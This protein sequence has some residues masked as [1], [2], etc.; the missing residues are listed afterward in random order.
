MPLPSSGSISLA[1][2]QAE[3]GDSGSIALS[4]LYTTSYTKP[5]FIGKA[6]A[7]SNTTSSGVINVPNDAEPSDRVYLY[8]VYDNSTAT[9]PSITG[10]TIDT[11]FNGSYPQ[12]FP[13]DPSTTL[14]MTSVLLSGEVGDTGYSITIPNNSTYGGYVAALVVLRDVGSYSIKSSD[15]FTNPYL[16]RSQRDYIMSSSVNDL[17]IA[18]GAHDGSAETFTSWTLDT[19][20][21]SSYTYLSVDGAVAGMAAAIGVLSS[22][23][24]H[25]SITL[26]SPSTAASATPWCYFIAQG[27]KTQAS[28]TIV[29][30]STQY[31][32]PATGS[33][34]L[35]D[36][37]GVNNVSIIPLQLINFANYSASGSSVNIDISSYVDYKD[38]WLIVSQG[39]ADGSSSISNNVIITGN[40]VI[41]SNIYNS[42]ANINLGYY[43][44]LNTDGD[45]HFA[46]IT[47]AKLQ[48]N[49][50]TTSVQWV[51]SSG[52]YTKGDFAAV[53]LLTSVPVLNTVYAN[54]DISGSTTASI[55]LPS[56]SNQAVAVLV[57]VPNVTNA[58]VAVSN[59]SLSFTT[60]NMVNFWHNTLQR[61]NTVYSTANI[62][63]T[64]YG[65]FAG[66]S[67]EF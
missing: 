10:M 41:S 25:N 15:E 13:T 65:L 56:S 23:N 59:A 12:V 42:D 9:R 5:T 22:N 40:T 32:I 66:V 44:S 45:G 49:T 19:D 7:S 11:S 67:F 60:G 43:K 62:G 52:I 61:S 29:P 18:I 1:Q 37:Y 38:R 2:V 63:G 14:T 51:K 48:D 35:G 39:S 55:T 64:G 20:F 47:A 16:V 30:I 21:D 36:F 4:D 54:A 57:S 17:V 50:A 27:I 58:T 31:G 8:I 3:F 24:V 53:Y 33:I 34:S 6:F 46:S 26:T 28:N